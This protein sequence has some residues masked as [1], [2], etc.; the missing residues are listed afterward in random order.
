MIVAQN[1]SDEQRGRSPL[2]VGG[3]SI[4]QTRS[5][6]RS[7]WWF[8]CRAPE[9]TPARTLHA[10]IDS[11]IPTMPRLIRR[12]GPTGHALHVAAHPAPRRNS[13]QSARPASLPRVGR[14]FRLPAT[15]TP[16]RGLATAK[17]HIR[18]SAIRTVSAEH[19][20]N[21]HA[22]D[23]HIWFKQLILTLNNSR[24]KEGDMC[25]EGEST[26][27]PTC[28]ATEKSWLS[29]KHSSRL[30]QR[31]GRKAACRRARTPV[32]RTGEETRKTVQAAVGSHHYPDHPPAAR[33]THP[34]HPRKTVVTAWPRRH[35]RI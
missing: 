26:T 16:R 14:G 8:G 22:A 27:T 28:S 6:R 15:A 20:L 3:Q 1:F 23:L 30:P 31:S 25:P 9:P 19:D 12:H 35:R 13:S 33:H 29:T 32:H 21:P 5:A 4:G 17:G 34:R 7:R 2:R 11:P 24:Q 18:E 10:G